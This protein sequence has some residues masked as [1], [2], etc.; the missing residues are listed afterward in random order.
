VSEY[1]VLFEGTPA[2]K[3]F[4]EQVS[5]LEVEENADLPGAISL[6]L[7]V[8]VA[9][10][11]LTWVSDATLKPYANIAV[12]ATAPDAADACIFDGYVLT[13]KVH[14]PSG[15]AGAT[16]EAWGQDASVL[17]GLTETVKAWSG[18]SESDVA[19]QI[20][21]SYGFSAATANGKTPGP[22][23]SEDEHA[24]VQRGSDADF[25]RRL[26]RRTGRWFRVRATDKPGAREGW[27]AAPDLDAEPVVTIGVTDPAT[28]AVPVL[29]FSW[30]ASR[31]NAVASRQVS[32]SDNDK[33]GVS[34]DA[35][36][37]GLTPLDAR[38]LADFAGRSRT[39][40][41]TA[42]ADTAELPDRSA[43]LLRDAGWF[44]RCEGT[45][46]VN[47]LK[48]VL[49]VGELVEVEGCGSLLSGKYLV[50]SVR[51]TFTTQAHTMAFVL[52]RNALGAEG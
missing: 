2:E 3:D 5:R 46:D 23:H 38:P 33:A 32:F 12:T 8:G 37:S 28:S 25:L 19:A 41:L 4:Y 29:D 34:A 15:T 1:Q 52:V 40:I 27:F 42:A 9:D 16:L 17:M 22:T 10:G 45:A 26:A 14:L 35:S 20:F 13:H 30:D 47:V 21:S 7:P 31:P 11:E 18:M 44:V 43:G 39:V 36:D 48:H 51:H 24:L 50:W 6:T 49:R